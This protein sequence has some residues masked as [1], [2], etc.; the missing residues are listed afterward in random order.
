MSTCTFPHRNAQRRATTMASLMI[1]VLAGVIASAVPAAAATVGYAVVSATQKVLS[2]ATMS[3]TSS[4]NLMGARNEFVSF[5]VMLTG[6][7]TGV[8][9][10][11][12]TPLTGPGGTIPN[13]NITIYREEYFTTAQPSSAG[14]YVGAWPDILI[15][16]VDRLYGQARRAFPVDVPAGQNRVA[17][18]DVLIPHDQ[19][20]GGYDGSLVVTNGSGGSATV[21]VHVDVRNFTLP[22]T[23]SLR[24]LFSIGWNTGC[25]ALYGTCDAWASE[26]NL[27]RAW[28]T[29]YDFARLALDNRITIANPQFQPPTSGGEI[30]HFTTFMLPL[31]NGTAPTQLPGARLTSVNV[32]TGYLSTWR[33]LAQ[34]NGF[35]DRAVVYDASTCDELGANSTGWNTCRSAVTGY[36]NT[37]PGLP[38]VMTANIDEVNT[39]DPT[40]AITDILVPV[41]DQMDDVSGT[42]AGDQ[43]AKYSNFLSK[44]GKQVWLYTSCDVSGCSGANETDP[45]FAHPWI[46]Y[47]IDTKAAQNRAM[48][49]LDYVYNASG[50]L[51]YSTTDQLTT[52]WTN[53]W[54]FGG[55]GDGTLYYPGTTARIGGTTPIPLESLR[56]KMIRNGYQDYEYLRLATAAG[57]GTQAMSI[58][59]S[60]YPS[61]HEAGPTAAAIDTARAQLADLIDPRPAPTYTGHQLCGPATV[62]GQL[63][64]YTSLPAIS[65]SG[66]NNSTDTRSGWTAQN[67]YLGYSISDATINV[68]QTGRDGEL[69]NGDGVEVMI[70]R[71]ATRPSTPNANDYHLLINTDNAVTD[72]RGT[73]TGWDRTW[74]ANATTAVTRTATGYTV[75]IA[76]PWTAI[77]GTPTTGATLGLDVANNDSDTPGQVT[78]YDWAHLTRFAQPQAWGILTLG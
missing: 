35:T 78:P 75:E 40:Y 44:P 77:G 22:S 54:G 49:W 62:D 43:H 72:E 63:G 33:S 12:G 65:F 73:G 70:D 56:M 28:R 9:V 24:S 19:P 11:T 21:P 74:T 59:K 1:A 34:S 66:A 27:Q 41:V 18:V 53:Q 26:A 61:T 37:W 38:N 25:E 31:I 15:P 10:A 68:N 76:V 13:A 52:A 16:T 60:I 2:T 46:D 7:Q 17:F 32:D 47:T 3:G 67:L 6:G 45:K 39:Y 4:A 42:Y 36:K 8:S 51:Y 14:R 71:N 20:A 58:A 69:W 50:E 57:L 30:N 64:E 5:Q 55:N 48:G 29:N 23:S